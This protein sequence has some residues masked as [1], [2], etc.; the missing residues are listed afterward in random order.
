MSDKD[1]PIAPVGW[2]PNKSGQPGERFWDGTGWTGEQRG[3][4]AEGKASEI[5]TRTR[6]QWAFLASLVGGALLLPL[7]FG[8]WNWVGPGRP[9]ITTDSEACAEMS[10]AIGI[11][12]VQNYGSVT[13][14]N[15]ENDVTYNIPKS[16]RAG[17]GIDAFEGTGNGAES[18]KLIRALTILADEWT[19]GSDLINYDPQDSAEEDPKYTMYNSNNDL[20]GV[21]KICKEL[22]FPLSNDALNFDIPKV[23]AVPGNGQSLPQQTVQKFPAGY[24][25]LGVGIAVKQVDGVCDYLRCAIYEVY[26]YKT[27]PNSVYLEG[28]QVDANGVIY[29]ITNDSNGGM[30]IGDLAVMTLRA[31]SNSATGVT[32]TDAS[33]Y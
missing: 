13:S 25:D 31:T 18:P 30:N 27:C 4:P 1:V 23:T 29:G 17:A 33:C 5:Q 9:F 32:I 22:G 6:G 8:L 7:G 26:A 11:V 2:Y 28:S 14:I 24:T 15:T 21:V 3:L 10:K 19:F 12:N 20:R 16:A